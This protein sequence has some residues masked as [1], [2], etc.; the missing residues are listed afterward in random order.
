MWWH[1]TS[2]DRGYRYP[3]HRAP[4][5]RRYH[6]KS[7]PLAGGGLVTSA[8]LAPI[9]AFELNLVG[10]GDLQ[11]ANFTSGAGRIDYYALPSL[12]PLNYLPSCVANGT[13]TG[14]RSNSTYG[15]VPAVTST[16]FQQSFSF[17]S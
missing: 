9:V 15:T 3:R 13:T 4:S 11:Y 14:E 1:F 7:I 5:A 2:R 16:L 8:Y 12:T 17:R 6:L 10:P